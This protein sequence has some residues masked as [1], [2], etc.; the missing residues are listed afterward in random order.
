MTSIAS[1]VRDVREA[2][3]EQAVVAESHTRL[4]VVDFWAPWCGPCRTLGPI[5]E[6][7][8]A[9]QNGAVLLAKVNV[10][11][12]QGLSARFR[13]QS[14]PAVKA[15]RDGKVVA[16]FTGALPESAVRRWLDPLL[17]PA[18]AG[19]AEQA[20]ALLAAGKAGEA[21]GLY[22]EAL[23]SNPGDAA[24]LRALAGLL[25]PRNPQAAEQAL[26]EAPAGT[27]AYL[28]ARQV[29]DAVPFFEAASWAPARDTLGDRA[30]SAD[31]YHLAAAKACE[32]Q[33]AE[34]IDLLL[35]VVM[36]DRAFRDDGARKALLGLL[37]LLGDEQPLVAPARRRLA[38]ALF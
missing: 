35:A 4:V 19:I 1:T 2:E 9:A 3:F 5:L 11:E 33:W 7:L 32:Q 20:T 17:P 38:N 16:E 36:T 12:S 31:R 22:R 10:D 30:S 26:S 21:E 6:R 15:F 8:V 13:V 37:A 14:I 18:G 23:A 25:L 28:L 24:S 27:P 29:L 34:A